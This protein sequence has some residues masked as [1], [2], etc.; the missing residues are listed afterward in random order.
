MS[1]FYPQTQE[2]FALEAEKSHRRDESEQTWL[3]EFMAES[4]VIKEKMDECMEWF[5]KEVF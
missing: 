3:D 5:D 1:G 4:A 2:S